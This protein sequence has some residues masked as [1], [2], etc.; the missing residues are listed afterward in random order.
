MKKSVLIYDV[1]GEGKEMIFVKVD[2][3]SCPYCRKEEL[4]RNT[5]ITPIGKDED[6]DLSAI[7]YLCEHCGKSF[8]I[9]LVDPQLLGEHNRK[10][11]ERFRAATAFN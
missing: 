10:N 4:W 11:L 8:L 3:L 9:T 1:L 5:D 6:T 2:A 7:S